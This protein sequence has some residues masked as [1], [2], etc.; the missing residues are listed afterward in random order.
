VIRQ[1]KPVRLSILDS[2]RVFGESAQCAEIYRT[3]DNNFPWVEILGSLPNAGSVKLKRE[4]NSDNFVA[5]L[6]SK[7]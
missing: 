7:V 1:S 5:A 4:P 6:S 2:F 3:T